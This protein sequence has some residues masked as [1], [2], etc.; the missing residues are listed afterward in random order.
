M[1]YGISVGW[2]GWLVGSSA[3][4]VLSNS[5][6]NYYYILVWLKSLVQ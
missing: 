1:K 3:Q 4:Q 2:F 5:Q 6:L